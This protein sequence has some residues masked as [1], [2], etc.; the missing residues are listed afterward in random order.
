MH[1]DLVVNVL[2]LRIFSAASKSLQFKQRAHQLDEHLESAE[3]EKKNNSSKHHWIQ[4]LW[5]IYSR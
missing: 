3:Q 4:I 2:S 5:I 1:H